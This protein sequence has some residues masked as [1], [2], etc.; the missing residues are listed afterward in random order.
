MFSVLTHLIVFPCFSVFFYIILK[1]NFQIFASLLAD[2]LCS[3]IFVVGFKSLQN[4]FL[5]LCSLSSTDISLYILYKNLN[6]L[7][8][9]T[10]K[11]IV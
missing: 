7:T 1:F 6:I 5:T 4:I 3:S 9:K 10:T 2:T 11:I 8:T